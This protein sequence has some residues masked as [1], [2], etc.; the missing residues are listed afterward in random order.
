MEDF[1][2]W[3][4]DGSSGDDDDD[5]YSDDWNSEE[6]EHPRKRKPGRPKGSKNSTGKR[7]PGRPPGS[8]SKKVKQELRES[9]TDKLAFPQEGER[10]HTL[11]LQC[12]LCLYGTNDRESLIQHQFR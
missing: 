1:R 12:D 4:C 3:R 6:E 7:G 9:H 5:E 8:G 11:K 10:D 2:W